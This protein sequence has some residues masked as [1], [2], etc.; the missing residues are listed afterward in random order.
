MSKNRF[1]SFRSQILNRKK[2]RG[3]KP[4]LL[5]FKNMMTS[6]SEDVSFPSFMAHKFGTGTN[7]KR[8]FIRII[9][10]FFM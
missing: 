5:Y 3:P 1:I 8:T 9:R 4:N 7:D 2:A 10:M 6:Q